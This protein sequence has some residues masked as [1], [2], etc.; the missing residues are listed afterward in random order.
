MRSIIIKRFIKFEQL[1]IKKE[2]EKAKYIQK[3]DLNRAFAF[4]VTSP[5]FAR[6]AD[7]KQ[8]ASFTLIFLTSLINSNIE[9]F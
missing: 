7:Q 5:L 1:Q 9:K 4:H 8:G 6:N 3:N 2:C